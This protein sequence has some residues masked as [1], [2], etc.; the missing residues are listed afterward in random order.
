MKY[1]MIFSIG[2]V[3]EFI[4]TARRSRDLWYGSWM[5][6]EL[7][8][9]AAK[10]ING[11]P[12]SGELIFPN[13]EN[14]NDL[15]ASSHFTSPNKIVAVVDAKPEEAA[16]IIR[17]SINQRMDNLWED[18]KI[19]GP[20]NKK[21]AKEQADDLIEFSWVSAPYDGT[22][23]GYMKAREQAEALLAARKATRKFIQPTWSSNE[24]KSSLDGARE[25]VIPKSEY[26]ER[27]DPKDEKLQRESK[28]K[29]E[30]LYKNYHARRG[31][32]LSG[33]DLLKRLGSP[34]EARKFRSTS[35]MAGIPFFER[36][37]EGK[38]QKLLQS[39]K[40]LLPRDADELD[41]N[42]E[43][44]VFESRLKDG[45]PQQELPDDVKK[46]FRELLK[47]L[48]T[49]N[50]YYALL[51]ADGDFM[52]KL[53]DE[54]HQKEDHKRVSKS[55]AEFAGKALGLVEDNNGVPIYLGGDDVLAFLPLTTAL[56]C[57]HELNNSFNATVGRHGTAKVTS[58]LSI[59][60]AIVHHLEPLSDALELARKAEKEAKKVSGKNG[61]AVILSKRS[62]A[63]RV[64]VGKFDDLY[65]RLIKLKGFFDAKSISGGAAY[66]L[67]NLHRTLYGSRIPPEG[68]AAEA[69]RIIGRKRVEGG[70]EISEEAKDSFKGWINSID[71]DE[72]ALEMIVAKNLA[73]VEEAK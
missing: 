8:K 43:G 31:E 2:P 66:E 41:R 68:K 32:Q 30:N 14:S 33:V 61:L 17:A 15:L 58:T 7:S 20:Y 19:N 23:E 51:A 6:S 10:A 69:I 60:I 49:P 56:K 47:D 1:L 71:L 73:I 36:L 13:P 18:T 16:T 5:L 3:Q 45:F 25:S 28:K 4:A 24:P 39:L 46:K 65:K 34:T 22:K 42:D 27:G 72:L 11:P 21:A 9:A 48:P 67:Q 62:G 63:D 52:G 70:K 26:P 38:G 44:L 40:V 59:G 53:I 54:H 12:L 37:D 57:A 35:D 55:L 64:V 50:P 29:I